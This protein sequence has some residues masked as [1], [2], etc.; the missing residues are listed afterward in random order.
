MKS[1]KNER[2]I[3]CP[4]CPEGMSAEITIERDKITTTSRCEH[5][6]AGG[7]Y[8]LPNRDIRGK[9]TAIL[10]EKV[11]GLLGQTKDMPDAEIVAEGYYRAIYAFRPSDMGVWNLHSVG[12]TPD[13]I[14]AILGGQGIEDD[15]TVMKAK[16]KNQITIAQGIVHGSVKKSV[17]EID[18]R[19]F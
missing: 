18:L 10:A 15:I 17:A 14:E 19:R 16:I 2:T 8:E 12:S 4:K 9:K 13:E 1:K 3:P 11:W 6:G 5:C 7:T